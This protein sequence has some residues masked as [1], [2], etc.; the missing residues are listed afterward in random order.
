MLSL[1]NRPKGRSFALKKL[2]VLNAMRQ[3]PP[4]TLEILGV[5]FS[6]RKIIE[7]FIKAGYTANLCSIDLSK[8][9]DKVNHNC[10]FLKLMNRHIPVELLQCLENFLS[11]CNACVKWHDCWSDMFTVN[12]GVRQGS[13]M[14]PLLFNIY[15]DELTSLSDGNHNVFIIAYADDI[16][17]LTSSCHSVAKYF[18]SM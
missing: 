10:L 2:D 16:L 9:F 13:V 4:C 1:K 5:C 7:R 15:I 17:L 8:A 18:S 12:F 11:E 6:D 3:T 14:S